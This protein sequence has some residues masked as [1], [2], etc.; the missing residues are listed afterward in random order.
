MPLH[1]DPANRYRVGHPARAASGDEAARATDRGTALKFVVAMCCIAA[2]PALAENWRTSASA[3]ATETYTS[4]VDYAP[5]GQTTGDLVTTLSATFNIHG[6]GA[7]VRLDG[8][9]GASWLLYAGQTQN[10]SI[11]PTVNLAG[12]VEAIE[13]FAF[14]EASANVNTSFLSP[15]GPQPASLVNATNN[16]YI[17]ETY[18]VSPY[19]QGVLGSTNISYRVPSIISTIPRGRW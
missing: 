9:I 15:F 3:S 11:A 5:Q 4:N 10:N 2:A 19:I 6:E 8:S 18:R 7:R 1:R 16:R 12:R 13:K 14:V 17:S